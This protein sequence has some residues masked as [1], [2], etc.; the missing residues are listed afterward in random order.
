LTMNPEMSR[1]TTVSLPSRSASAR[2]VW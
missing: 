2:V 1:E